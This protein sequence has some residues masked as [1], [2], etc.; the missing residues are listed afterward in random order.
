MQSYERVSLSS[1]VQQRRS[2]PWDDV[3]VELTDEFAVLY[4]VRIKGIVEKCFAYNQRSFGV[5][6]VR[7][8]VKF[9]IDRLN[10]T[11][12]VFL[13]IAPRALCAMT[14]GGHGRGL[15]HR[16]GIHREGSR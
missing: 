1:I 14:D 10:C 13:F 9:R 3:E 16:D 6:Q 11:S 4:A 5:A 15:G 8:R 2:Y 7:V 12:Y